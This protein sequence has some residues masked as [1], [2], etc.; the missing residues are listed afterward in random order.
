MRRQAG[1]VTEK[2][3]IYHQLSLEINSS[4]EKNTYYNVHVFLHVETKHQCLF[5]HLWVKELFFSWWAV[6][7]A[8][9]TAVQPFPMPVIVHHKL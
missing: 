9:T 4:G 8:K 5:L 1:L 6:A 2:M 3:Y 7:V